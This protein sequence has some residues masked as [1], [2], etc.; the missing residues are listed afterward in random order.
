MPLESERRK[1]IAPS[2][3]VHNMANSTRLEEPK[4]LELDYAD[5]EPLAGS[6]F[7]TE[8]ADDDFEDSFESRGS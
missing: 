7:E 1:T 8:A 2:E 6:G 5:A 4:D 3:G